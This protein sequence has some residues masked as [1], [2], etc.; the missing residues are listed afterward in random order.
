MFD[1]DTSHVRDATRRTVLKVTAGALGLA[2][3]GTANAHEFGSTD[4]EGDID[5][6]DAG[7]T[8]QPGGM[9]NSVVVGYHSLGAVGDAGT[10]GRPSSPHYGGRTEL[11]T[12]GDYAYVSFFSSDSPTPGRGMAIVDIS[13]YNE[14]ETS[15][16]RSPPRQTPPQHANNNEEAETADDRSSPGEKPPQHAGAGEARTSDDLA[17]AEP[18]VVSFLRNNSTATAC[19]DLKVDDTGDYVFIGTQPYTALFSYPEAGDNPDQARHR[20]ETNEAGDPTPNTD[21]HSGTEVPGAVIAINV[22]DKGNPQRV[23]AFQV[24]GTGIHNLYHHRIGT[25]EYVFAIHDLDDGTE[26]IY[27]FRFHRSAERLELVNRWT[28]DGNYRQGDVGAEASY[29][30]DLEV[31]NDPRTGRPTIYLAYWGHGLRVLDASDPAN[32]VQLG[33]FDMGACHFA[34]SLPMLVDGRRVA[35]ASQEIAGSGESTGTIHLVDVEGIYPDHPDEITDGISYDDNGIASLS[36]HDK[37]EW[38]TTGSDPHAAVKNTEVNFNAFE[39]S[40]HNSELSRHVSPDGEGEFWLHQ[41]HYHGGIRYLK[42]ETGGNE[43]KF[44]DRGFARPKYDAVPEES[45]MQGLNTTQ[46]NCWTAV[47]SNGVTF[48][49]DIN[50]GVH[51][52]KHD[53][54]PLGG[55]PPIVGVT[56]ES[57]GALT[58]G[59]TTRID[60]TVDY[61]E[62]YDSVRLRDRVATSWE[63]HDDGS[64]HETYEE[65]GARMVEFRSGAMEGDYFTYFASAPSGIDATDVYRFG[66]VE[67]STDEG[68]S[69]EAVAGT[70]STDVVVGQ[71]TSTSSSTSDLTL[72][73]AVGAIGAAYHQREALRERIQGNIEVHSDQER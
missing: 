42:L 9:K 30:H 35:I 53:N 17:M 14:A 62:R 68:R 16:Q 8:D 43:Y 24:S 58:G 5:G 36:E 20:I 32:L 66:P 59:Q 2:A 72:G 65:G 38:Q 25:E 55:A 47:E 73:T 61:L 23:D 54:I 45:M 15:N 26:G 44:D 13:D 4:H 56:R 19:M 11:R 28:L 7:G 33:H 12:R 63:V 70:I 48:A 51:A 41:G 39:L 52:V 1:L 69:W 67:V 31:H 18:T 29:I 22:E 10:A 46:P 3:A 71:S 21:D 49:S 57:T 34:T 50:Q 37:W 6:S 60:L 40:P 27:V 64:A